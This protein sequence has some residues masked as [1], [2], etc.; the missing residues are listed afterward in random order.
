[1]K[2]FIDRAVLL[3]YSLGTLFLLETSPVFLVAFLCAVMVSSLGYCL[4]WRNCRLAF[5]I[6]YLVCS[7]FYMEFI[8]FF[9]VIF[10]GFLEEKT[11]IFSVLTGAI[12]LRYFF[13]DYDWRLTFFLIF[14]GVLTFI[15]QYRTAEYLA[16]DIA[17]K[18]SRDD[19]T[20]LNLLLKQKNQF[21]LEKQDYEIYTATLKERNRIAREIHDN[22]GHLLSRSILMTGAAKTLNRDPALSSFLEQLEDTLNTAM[23]GVRES[24]HDLHDDSI[25][26]RGVLSELTEGFT[27][28]PVQ[29]NYD[30][31]PEIPRAVK[32]SF[33]AIVKEA[34]TNIMKHSD[35]TKV[36][37]SLHE[38]PGIYQLIIEDNGSPSPGISCDMQSDP[39]SNSQSDPLECF[40]G[41]G[42]GLA[43]MRDR[44]ATLHGTIQIQTQKGFRIFITVPKSEFS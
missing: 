17:F 40:S 12:C 23:T 30:M 41:S 20:E 38:H 44:V 26:L 28:C 37:L 31:G 2:R 42:M 19:S 4:K 9:P 25:D 34:L 3:I 16:H 39:P 32:Y 6:L 33:I 35:A 24:V 21:L 8:L 29:F 10:Y 18:K 27:F 36:L 22:V 1:M 15:L 43:N 11:H 5:Y 13:A 7:L 14:G